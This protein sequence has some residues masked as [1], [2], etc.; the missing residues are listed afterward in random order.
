M[1]R[2][3]CFAVVSSLAAV[4][5]A[6]GSTSRGAGFGETGNATDPANGVQLGTGSGGDGG[7]V[8]AP[9]PANYD[10]PD[11]ECDDD[12][13]GTIDNPPSCDDKLAANGTAE[14]FARAIGICTKADDAG[15]GLVS[16]AF[17]RGYG[18]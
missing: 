6:C 3:M 18:R 7:F 11:N 14:D 8:S 1:H 4:F 13:D 16:A 10:L 15:Y 2:S 9:D 12:G 17:T 5:V